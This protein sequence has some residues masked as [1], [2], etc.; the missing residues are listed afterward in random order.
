MLIGLFYL[1]FAAACFY[2]FT[3]QASIIPFI[4]CVGFLQDPARKLMTGEPAYMTILVGVVIACALLNKL[5]TQPNSLREPFVRWSNLIALPLGVYF[6]IL[7]AQFIHAFVRYDSVILPAL[8]SVFYIAPIVAISVGYSQFL[9]FR[10]MRAFLTLFIGFALLVAITV[11]LSFNNVQSDLFGEVGA[12]LIIYDQ[13][14]ILRAYSGI[15][16]S[17]EIAGWHMGA[18]VC[19]LV[20]LA[21]DR[22]SMATTIVTTALVVLIIS[23]IILT[24]RR[25]MIAQIF[26]F[27]ALYLPLLRFYQGRLAAGY[28][29]GIVFIVASGWLAYEVLFSQ[30]IGSD[31]NLYL[32]RGTS[33]FG[34]ATGR[35]EQLGLGSI[36]WAVNR[37]GYF[38]GGL[39]VAAQGAQ[40][41]GGALAG[42]AGEGG[43][44][45]L[46]SEIGFVSLFVVAWVFY[47][48]SQYLH[49]C[50]RLVA[51]YV[52]VKLPIVIGVFC[53]L[54]SNAP[55][56]I[57]ASQ[58]FGDVFVLLV[59][60]LL[61]GFLFAIPVQVIDELSRVKQQH[62]SP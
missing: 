27:A 35:F 6:L 33:V 44:G 54:I 19:F 28:F 45:K 29:I 26:I 48:F 2:A 57:V 31:F 50:V 42:G 3:R 21:V 32:R 39:G 43:L 61:V 16:R 30:S 17:S 58:V 11:I 9:Q 34:D 13:G 5:A 53:F 55:T 8:G 15:M 60:G 25:K 36:G 1:F 46:V 59:L 23:A 62:K 14:T 37:F 52:P 49:R 4:V 12:G 56:F 51:V 24:G 38:G 40:H 10:D 47:S 22:G 20:I 41:F 18:C 7:G